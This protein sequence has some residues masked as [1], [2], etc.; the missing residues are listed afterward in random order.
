MRFLIYSLITLCLVFTNSACEKKPIDIE[1]VELLKIGDCIDIWQDEVIIDDEDTF[2]SSIE[3]KN[4]RGGCFN[5]E[6]PTIDFTER[7]V[8]GKKTALVACDV[9][10]EQDVKA[11]LK[12]KEYIYTIRITP[13]IGEECTDTIY[14]GNWISVPKLPANYNVRFELDMPE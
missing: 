6:L 8:L 10:Y 9:F 4:D 13:S 1:G 7:T 5:Y 14:S 2:E 11:D 12:N 3:H